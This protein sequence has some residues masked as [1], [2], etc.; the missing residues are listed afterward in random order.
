MWD[1]PRRK[2]Q[3]IQIPSQTTQCIRQTQDIKTFWTQRNDRCGGRAKNKNA[4]QFAQMSFDISGRVDNCFGRLYVAIFTEI[5]HG[6]P[7]GG[8]IATST[9]SVYR[10]WAIHTARPVRG[11]RILMIAVLFVRIQHNAAAFGSKAI[12]ESMWNSMMLFAHR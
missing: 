12:L 1:S 11:H 3:S 8:N 9:R 7:A 10:W 6:G 2:L 4:L 5:H